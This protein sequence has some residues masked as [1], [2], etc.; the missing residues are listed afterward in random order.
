MYKEGEMAAGRDAGDLEPRACVE[1]EKRERRRDLAN[2]D[3]IERAGKWEIR[4]LYLLVLYSVKGS[5][6]TSSAKISSR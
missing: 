6:G 4:C 3:A 2:K 5:S 1:A